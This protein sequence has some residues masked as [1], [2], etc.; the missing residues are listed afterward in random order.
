M[1]EYTY[2]RLNSKFK[3]KILDLRKSC[4]FYVVFDLY[5]THNWMEINL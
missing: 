2:I 4:Y 3:I 5:Q 1:L